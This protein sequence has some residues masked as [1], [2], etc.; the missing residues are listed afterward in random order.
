MDESL[1]QKTF[2]GLVWNFLETF[3]LQGFGFVQ[4]IIL[5][6]HLLPSDYGLIA[7]TGALFAISYTLIDSGFT[8]SLVRKNNRTEEDYSTVYVTN[9]VLSFFLSVG[10][11]LCASVIADFYE[12]PLLEKIVYLNAL[13]MFLN[14]FVAV[15]GTKLSIQLDFKTKSIINVVATIVAGVGAIVMVYCGLGVWSLI[16]PN[17]VSL[18]IKAALYWHFQH[19]FPGMNFSWEIYREHFSYGVK[20]MLAGLVN[21]TYNSMYPLVIGKKYSSSDLGFYNKAQGYA[22]LPSSVISGILGKVTFPVLSQIQN[23][24]EKL[25]IVYRKMIRVSAYIVFPIMVL[26]AVLA[27]P[28]VIVLI[29]EKWLHCVVYLQIL[30]FAMMW[31]PI[32]S[33]SC[34]LLMLKG[35][36][37][38]YL[39]MEIVK[40]ILGVLV[41]CATI[42]FGLDII[43][44]GQV[45]VAMMNVIINVY[46]IGKFL[47]LGVVA[48]L[49]DMFPSIMYSLAMGGFV[50]SILQFVSS[51]YIQ[52]GLG[53]LLGIV[54]YVFLSKLTSSKDL[55]FLVEMIGQK[56]SNKYVRALISW[57]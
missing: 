24:D 40:K 46:Y 16:Y 12:E 29:T 7:M 14:S 2:S 44:Y 32:N 9:V 17:F 54:F 52:I 50:W 48:Q 37:V 34:N 10:I 49:R 43:C 39:R 23:D 42:P 47:N 6:R 30:C 19:W 25:K 27:R 4:G 26:L 13:L 22:V 45:F 53:L 41:L 35:H 38:L 57:C 1:K 21:S 3:A 31:D 55:C 18:L 28:F 20:I 8:V 33:L 11:S 36:S 51:D 15:Q 56:T 5:A